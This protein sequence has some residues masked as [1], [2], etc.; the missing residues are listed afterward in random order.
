MKGR[1]DTHKK[2][3][4]HH[5][6]RLKLAGEFKERFVFVFWFWFFCFTL[7]LSSTL[8]L[9]FLAALVWERERERVPVR[10]PPLVA[11]P[12]TVGFNYTLCQGS[13]SCL[14]KAD[15]H[16]SHNLRDPSGGINEY[17]KVKPLRRIF[18]ASIKK[19]KRKKKEGE[20]K[21]KPRCQGFYEQTPRFRGGRD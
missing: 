13:G 14:F 19:K 20:T 3:Y 16:R 15:H 12:S 8:S 4:I 21:W 11:A 5:K 18:I 1:T 2:K 6:V 7:V 9:K 10:G 17:W